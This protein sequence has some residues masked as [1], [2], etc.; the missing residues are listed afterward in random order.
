MRKFRPGEV[1]NL[2]KVPKHWQSYNVKLE[3]YKL[4]CT[5]SAN[6]GCLWTVESWGFSLIFLLIFP[7]FSI[8]NIPG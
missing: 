1:E 2:A 5:Q 7:Y 4:W 3:G 8:F 6:S